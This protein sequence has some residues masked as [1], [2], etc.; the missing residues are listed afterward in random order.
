[1]LVLAFL[2]GPA[3]YI[4]INLYHLHFCKMVNLSL[5]YG[6]SD[7][8]TFGLVGFGAILCQPFC[9]YNDGYR[10]AKL[11]CD[12]VEKHGFAAYRSKVYL[13]MEMVAL[14]SQPIEVGVQLIRTALRAGAESGD[15]SFACFSCM[16][17]ITA[18]LSQGVPLNEVWRESEN[19]LDLVRRSK[20]VDATDAIISQRQLI[21][22][23]RGQTADFS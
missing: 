8:S 16:H 1:M 18:L 5:K 22:N 20:Y 4:D 10:F 23:L 21:R 14:W 9:R 15:L 3:L 6:I 2:T 7:A 13:S 12:L 17:L 19:C 11:A